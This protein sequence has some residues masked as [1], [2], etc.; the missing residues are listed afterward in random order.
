MY[1]SPSHKNNV[2][3]YTQKLGTF[4]VTLNQETVLSFL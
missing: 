1:L 4:L 3:T 2:Y